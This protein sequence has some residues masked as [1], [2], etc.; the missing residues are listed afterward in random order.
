[1]YFLGAA[2]AL[3]RGYNCLTFEGPG[4]GTVARKQKLPFRPDWE[5]VSY[6]IDFA[7]SKRQE[8]ADPQRM[9]LIGYSMGGYLGPRAAAFEDR[10]AACIADDG[11][12][13]IY[14]AWI[15]QVQA[16]RQDIENGNGAVVNAVIDTIM[17]F[18][19][20]TKWK[21]THSMSVFGVNSPLELIQKVSEYSMYDIAY[22]IKCPT[23]L[24]AGEKD[25][26][27]AGQAK[28]LYD[29][30]KCPKKYILFTSEEGAEDHCHVA[31]LSLANQR[32]FDWLDNI[33]QNRSS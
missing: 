24:L 21:I 13:S 10:I 3:K 22:K 32:I 23:L 14:D 27:F 33:L 20:G 5:I 7:V 19:I 2:A 25:H 15:D 8:E 6:V 12:V 4:Q 18:D 28:K 17:N 11:V 16:I 9:A 1:M 26:P 31:E 29:L 30:L